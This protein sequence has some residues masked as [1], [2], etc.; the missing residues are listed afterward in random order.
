MSDP[1][2]KALTCTKCGTPAAPGEGFC[3]N[4]GNQ[5]LAPT[6]TAQPPVIP[7]VQA[8]PPPPSLQPPVRKRRGKLL[9]G[10]LFI[11]GIGVL[12]AGAGVV[13]IWRAT[14]YS[15]PGRQAPDIPLRTAGTMTEFP[16]D[17]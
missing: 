5:L 6:I 10:C 13:F 1:T 12:V 11:V 3:R 4:C 9:L 7:P 14:S 15:P 17:N 16:V 2:I 8:S